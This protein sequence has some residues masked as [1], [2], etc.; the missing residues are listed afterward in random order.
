[1]ISRV[2]G[3]MVVSG[4]ARGVVSDGK[5]LQQEINLAL[6]DSGRGT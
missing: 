4:C 6:L 3:A 1:M 2:V 5:R